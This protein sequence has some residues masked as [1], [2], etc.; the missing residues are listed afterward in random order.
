MWA[1]G[2]G[3]RRMFKYAV[4]GGAVLTASSVE[5]DVAASRLVCGG[6]VQ[7]GEASYYYRGE[8]TANGDRF[9]PFTEMTVAHPDRDMLNG[10]L[11]ITSSDTGRRVVARVND[12]GPR[13]DL[14][15][16]LDMTPKVLSELGLSRNQGVYQVSLR[17]CTFKYNS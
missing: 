11:E 12:W 10:Y 3:L 2:M 9:Q 1:I 8:Y 7:E 14:N 17:R 15:R 6:P 13:R 4:I 5:A 16:V